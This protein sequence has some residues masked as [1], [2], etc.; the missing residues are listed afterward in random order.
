MRAAFP[1]PVMEMRRRGV[2]H[3]V[4]GLWP[5]LPGRV[6]VPRQDTAQRLVLHPEHHVVPGE[7]VLAEVDP[8]QVGDSL[9]QE[10]ELLVVAAKHAGRTGPEGIAEPDAHAALPEAPDPPPGV[11]HL[12]PEGPFEPGRTGDETI[13]VEEV[14]V[15]VHQETAVRRGGSLQGAGQGDPHSI[16]LEGEGLQ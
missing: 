2:H 8:P 14:G 6:E 11:E 7:V 9:V 12:P 15:R 3:H 4:E 10:G 16:S 5:P 1:R 13:I